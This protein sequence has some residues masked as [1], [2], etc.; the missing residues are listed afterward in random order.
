[1][2][3]VSSF[4]G[5]SITSL[6]KAVHS[7]VSGIEKPASGNDNNSETKITVE[8]IVRPQPKPLPASLSQPVDRTHEDLMA[9]IAQGQKKAVRAGIWSALLITL[10]LGGAAA[11]ALWPSARKSKNTKTRSRPLRGKNGEMDK[12]VQGLNDRHR[13]CQR[14]G[15]G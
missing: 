15:S 2:A 7:E 8:P 1:M 13:I 14:N 9:A 5:A 11:V 12:D 6:E 4:A 10:I 3:E